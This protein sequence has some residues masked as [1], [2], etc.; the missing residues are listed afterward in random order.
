MF[1]KGG[2]GIAVGGTGRNG[3]GDVWVEQ[4]LVFH[5]KCLSC[6]CCS[7]K[8]MNYIRNMFA[9]GGK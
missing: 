3:N 9:R 5:M 7:I 1:Y 8:G 2:E 4:I 6:A